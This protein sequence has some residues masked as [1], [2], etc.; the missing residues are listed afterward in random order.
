MKANTGRDSHFLAA[1]P[2]LRRSQRRFLGQLLLV[3]A[4]IV[5]DRRRLRASVTALPPKPPTDSR[6][7]I[8]D[9]DVVRSWR[10]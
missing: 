2:D 8:V 4:R 9:G 6:P 7:L 5:G 10:A 3:E 1:R